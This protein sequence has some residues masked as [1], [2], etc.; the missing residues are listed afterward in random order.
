MQ[1]NVL[2]I[3]VDK[4]YYQKRKRTYTVIQIKNK[5]IRNVYVYR[6]KLRHFTKGKTIYVKF[7]FTKIQTLYITRFF[8]NVWNW[9]LYIYKKRDTL[10]YVMFLYF[11][12]L[13]LRKMQD[14]LRY[15]FYIQKAWHFALQM[16]SWNFWNWR[17]GGG[18]VWKK[19]N[20][21]CVKFVYAKKIHFPLRFYIEK[22]RYFE[23]NF[24]IQKKMH[25]ALR[26]HT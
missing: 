11:K 9:Y 1:K 26:F 18:F 10:R 6:E 25:L 24:Y 8:M 2:Y 4:N 3:N 13:I 7:F 22:S 19:N 21:L 16:F 17:R 15:V 5:I 14:N 20:A 23:S 12:S